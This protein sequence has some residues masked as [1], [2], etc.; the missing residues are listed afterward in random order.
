[1]ARGSKRTARAAASWRLKF[2]LKTYKYEYER[3][4]GQVTFFKSLC[5]LNYASDFQEVFAEG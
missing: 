5:P 4:A 3:R 2:F 1:M